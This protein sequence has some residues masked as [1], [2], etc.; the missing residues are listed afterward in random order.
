MK[1]KYEKVVIPSIEDSKET[2]VSTGKGK[3]SSKSSKG[4]GSKRKSEDEDE[5]DS[6]ELKDVENEY[7]ELIELK[8]HLSEKLIQ[9]PKSK[10]LLNAIEEC[11]QAIRELV[12][13]TRRQNARKYHKMI[14]SEKHQTNEI[15]Y[16]KKKMSNKEQLRVMRDLKEINSHINIEKPYRLA[17]LDSKMPAKFK[18]IAMQKLNVLRSMDPGDNEYYKIKNWV[19]TFMKI[20]FGKYQDLSV[21]MV[22][23]IDKCHDFMENAKAKLDDCVYGHADA[24]LQIMQMMGQWISNPSAMGSA[25]AVK[26]PPGTGKCHGIDTPIL[27][28][29][30]TIKMVQDVI[31]GDLVMGDDSTPRKVLSLGRGEDE[32][33]DVVS[34]KGDVYTVNS[35]HIL[36]LMPSGLS[37]IREKKTKTGTSYKV[38]WFENST[39]SFSYKTFREKEDATSYLNELKSSQKTNIVEISVK[40]YL[41]LPK[42][43]QLP[44]KGFTSGVEFP[45]KPVIMNPYILGVW[46]GDGSSSKAN[47]TN[48][49]SSILLYLRNE[50]AK[51]NLSLKHV[52]KYDYAIIANCYNRPHPGISKSTGLP[53]ANKNSFLEA[54]RH[55]NLLNNKHIPHDYKSNDRNVRLQVLAGLIDTDGFYDKKNNSFEITQK[56][57]QLSDDI[58]YIIRS[59]GL[60]ATQRKCEKHCI[61]KGEKRSGTYYRLHI[62]GENVHEIPTKCPRKQ[63]EYRQ[64]QKNACVSEIKIVPKGRGDYY[65]F[66]LDNNHRYLL[67]NFVVTHNTS[68]IKEGVSKILGREFAF[69]ALG[70]TGDA[71]FLEGH[72]YTYEGSSWG[73][74]V[75]ILIDSKCMNPVIYF[76]E[77]DKVS[78]TPRGEEIIGI[79][80]HLTD[81]SQN[82]QYHDKYFAELDFD[83]SKCLFIFSY[84]DESKVNPILRDRMYRINTKGYEP[85]EKIVIARDYLLPKIR[86]QVNFKE[87]DII[88]PDETIQYI[89]SND[90]LTNQEAGVR[91]LKRCLEIIYTKINLFRLMKPESNIFGKDIDIKVTFPFT[92]TKKEV[93]IFI[94]SEGVNQSMLAM[95]V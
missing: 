62:Y 54:L 32:L 10:I 49:D 60:Y 16:F 73:K 61:Y 38:T 34:R 72:S 71:S 20:P 57:K 95:Y 12:K 50:F 47:I 3:G 39:H 56:S 68:L 2:K 86:E 63:A 74:I 15:E 26:G 5:E 27:M 65:G 48:Q 52:S 77:L 40:D 11:R 75:Q 53:Y 33:Y 87:E 42:A 83:L 18:A 51:Q 9:R 37:R 30:G 67:G 13:K 59:L 82:S 25:I 64:R 58:M 4:K 81:T 89:V 7:I 21:S 22:D 78:D 45:S 91:N 36:C 41:K 79:L 84:N 92:V 90:S 66:E 35:E 46:L 19:D 70:G 88:I 80:T 17:L 8:K 31:V 29:D 76:D 23:G 43:T 14:N 85:K 6:T 28:Y 44:L 69:I 24:K 55:Y 94:K 1:E 93:D